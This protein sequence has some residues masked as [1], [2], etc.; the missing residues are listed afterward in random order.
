MIVFIKL[1]VINENGQ[2]NAKKQAP[3][4]ETAPFVPP[5]SFCKRTNIS[6]VGFKPRYV[7]NET[8]N[9]TILITSA[10]DV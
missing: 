2:Q 10:R 3:N 5:W 8:D 6:E 7:D 1:F 4:F 9:F